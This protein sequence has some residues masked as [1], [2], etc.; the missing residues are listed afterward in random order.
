MSGLKM[1]KG[2]QSQSGIGL[3]S[4]YASASHKKLPTAK[5]VTTQN[6]FTS[7]VCGG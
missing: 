3:G 2:Q 7:K 5:N 6:F 4:K 1:S